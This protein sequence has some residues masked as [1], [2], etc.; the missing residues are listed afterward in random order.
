MSAAIWAGVRGTMVPL[1]ERGILASTVSW[2][3]RLT[4]VERP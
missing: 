4:L 2:R 3:S 1:D